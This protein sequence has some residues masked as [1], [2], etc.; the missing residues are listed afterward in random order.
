MFSNQK[1]GMDGVLCLPVTLRELRP[2]I[3]VYATN[4]VSI[5]VAEP[6]KFL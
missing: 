2:Q 4:G 6:V 3:Q 1:Y 5:A